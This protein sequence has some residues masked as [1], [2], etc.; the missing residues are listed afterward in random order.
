[1]LQVFGGLDK[2]VSSLAKPVAASSASSAGSG[3]PA[4][5]AARNLRMAA[6]SDATLGPGVTSSLALEPAVTLEGIASTLS[7]I[8]SA[9]VAL[10][11]NFLSGQFLPRMI[12]AGMPEVTT[13][14]IGQPGAAGK[15]RRFF[16]TVLGRFDLAVKDGNGKAS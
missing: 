2:L 14:E 10:S 15:S 3:G 5:Q 16:Q 1:M 12:P 8:Y 13:Q 9:Q 4:A 7:R 11:R 6:D